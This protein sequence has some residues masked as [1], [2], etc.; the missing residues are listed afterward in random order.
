[1]LL[2]S[3]KSCCWLADVFAP[4]AVR[5]ISLHQTKL[6]QNCTDAIKANNSSKVRVCPHAG[7]KL[8]MIALLLVCCCFFFLING[9]CKLFFI[10][11]PFYILFLYQF[12]YFTKELSLIFACYFPSCPQLLRVLFISIVHLFL[13]LVHGLLLYLNS[14]KFSNERADFAGEIWFLTDFM[15]V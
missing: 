4:A 14:F 10:V 12:L 2:S 7:K 15:P 13:H 3:Q 1:M 9:R 6:K 5:L 8:F 11:G